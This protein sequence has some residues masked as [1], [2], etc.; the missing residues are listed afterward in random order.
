LNIP[1]V[2]YLLA[3][4]PDSPL[5]LPAMQPSVTDYYPSIESGKIKNSVLSDMLKVCL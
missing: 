2:E 4:L 5:D 1:C 3:M